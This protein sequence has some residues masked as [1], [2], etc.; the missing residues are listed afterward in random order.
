M[1][2]RLNKL[3]GG[4][5]GGDSPKGMLERLAREQAL[6]SSPDFVFVIR[7]IQV[8]HS[9]RFPIMMD[10]RKPETFGTSARLSWSENSTNDSAA[11]AFFF[12][13]C[14]PVADVDEPTDVCSW[15]LALLLRPI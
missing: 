8:D 13:A 14:T 11:L 10:A 15:Q 6:Q 3:T 5:I 7:A 1:T 2:A 9:A 12:L 4:I